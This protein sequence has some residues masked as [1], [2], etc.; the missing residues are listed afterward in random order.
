MDQKGICLPCQ[1]T[2][3]LHTCRP[4]LHLQCASRQAPWNPC[5]RPTRGASSAAAAATSCLACDYNRQLKTAGR[6]DGHRSKNE[7][8]SAQAAAGSKATAERGEQARERADALGGMLKKGAGGGLYHGCIIIWWLICFPCPHI[9]TAQLHPTAVKPCTGAAAAVRAAQPGAST[10][11]GSTAAGWAGVCG[12]LL[13]VCRRGREQLAG[14]SVVDVECLG[15]EVRLRLGK[16]DE[17]LH[18]HRLA[19][20]ASH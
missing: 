8:R 12:H 13:L 9:R 1:R 10:A 5:N 20:G 2:R 15:N 19:R 18:R 14:C 6:A 11:S 17:Q 3:L 4:M 16:G 7:R